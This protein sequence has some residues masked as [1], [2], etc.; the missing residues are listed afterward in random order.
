VPAFRDHA[1]F[2]EQI[3]EPPRRV[4]P[5]GRHSGRAP[6]RVR[7]SRPD[8]RRRSTKSRIV[9]KWMLG[10]SYQL[11]GRFSVT[12]C[13][14][15][16]AGPRTRQ[17]PKFG[18]DT[19]ARRPMRSRCSSTQR[20]SRVACMVCDRIDVVERI[21]R[22]VG[23]IGVGVAL[24]HGQALGH[25]FVHA[26]ARLSSMPRPSTWR[27]SAPGS[28]AAARRRRSRRR[29]RASRARP[30]RRSAERSTRGCARRP[31]IRPGCVSGWHGPSALFS[32]PRARAADSRK[33]PPARRAGRRRGPCRSRSRRS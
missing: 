22:I 27:R 26:G 21:V 2:A 33:P 23:Q 29:A 12:A 15:T 28:S 31:W 32:P 24:D 9:Q 14:R 13:G 19:I 11:T 3:P 18:N 10:V 4:E 30:C 7:S 5:H 16:T 20:G 17:W 8:A 6:R 1:L 25:A